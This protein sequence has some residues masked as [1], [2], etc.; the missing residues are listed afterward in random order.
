VSALGAALG[1]LVIA[2]VDATARADAERQAVLVRELE[3]VAARVRRLTPLATSI[4]D[5][6]RRRA[7]ELRDTD[8]PADVRAEAEA[9]DRRSEDDTKRFGP[10]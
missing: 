4:E 8:P 6:V 10:G 9:R 5:A 2:V 1:E 7:E 3:D